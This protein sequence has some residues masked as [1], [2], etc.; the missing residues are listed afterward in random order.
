MPRCSTAGLDF[1]I[2]PAGFNA[3]LEFLTGFTIALVVFTLI[4]FFFLSFLGLPPSPFERYQD[5]RRHSCPIIG[6]HP[7]FSEAL[8]SC[9]HLFPRDEMKSL[10][11]DRAVEKF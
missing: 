7:R 6:F 11:E 1:I 3:P 4:L 10:E 2:I 9:K 8:P 5:F